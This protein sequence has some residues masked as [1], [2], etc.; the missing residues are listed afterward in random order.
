MKVYHFYPNYYCRANWTSNPF[1]HRALL[2]FSWG[3]VVEHSDDLVA[4]SH[5]AS[6]NN[7]GSYFPLK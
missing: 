1:L 5:Y 4:A 3:N 6:L 2:E 7:R